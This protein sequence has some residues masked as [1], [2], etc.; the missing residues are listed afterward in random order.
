[1]SFD[2]KSLALRAEALDHLDSGFDTLPAFEA[3]ADLDALRPVLLAA[4][5]RMRDNYPYQHPLYAGQMLKPP[6]LV[7]RLA[8]AMA[9]FINPNNH[10]MGGGLAS[11][12]MEREAMAEIANMFGWDTHLGHLTGGG[13][14]ANM[15]ALWVAGRM[16]PQTRRTIPAAASAKF[17]RYRSLRLPAIQ[18]AEWIWRRWNP[19][20][21]PAMLGL[22]SP[23]WVRQVSAQPTHFRRF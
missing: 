7:A 8:Y 5:E 4:A 6:H 14:M 15:E 18:N 1:M 12:A 16:S 13:T 23:P 22:S 3:E 11:S 2:R 9:Q 21:R 20:Y 19:P 17:C 10:A